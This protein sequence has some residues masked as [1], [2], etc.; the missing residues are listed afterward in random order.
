[1]MWHFYE[2]PYIP[3]LELV[4]YQSLGE[5][6]IDGILER[7]NRFLRQWQRN[8]VLIHTTLHFFLSYTHERP[9]GSRLQIF[10]AFSSDQ[11]VNFESIDAGFGK[12]LPSVRSNLK[13]EELFMGLL[14]SLFSAAADIAKETITET[15]NQ[16]ET[17]KFIKIMMER[18][19]QNAEAN[20]KLYQDW[21][22]HE[23]SNYFAAKKNTIIHDAFDVLMD[24]FE[25]TGKFDFSAVDSLSD[26]LKSSDSYKQEAADVVNLCCEALVKLHQKCCISIRFVMQTIHNLQRFADI[27]PSIRGLDR[28][29]D[30][31][32]P[33]DNADC[34]F[35]T[36]F[37]SIAEGLEAAK[38]DSDNYLAM[39]GSNSPL[40]RL[41]A[42]KDIL[43][44]ED[45]VAAVSNLLFAD[46]EVAPYAGMKKMILCLSMEETDEATALLLDTY[47][48]VIMNYLRLS[49]AKEKVGKDN[50]FIS[51]STEQILPIDL[52]IAQSIKSSK[53]GSPQE[54]DTNLD[55]FLE[56]YPLICTSSWEDQLFILQKV[57]A[58]LKMYS[59]ERKVLE[60]LVKNNIPRTEQIDRRLNFLKNLNQND[61][62]NAANSIEE[63]SIQ[64][65]DNEIAY[66]YRFISWTVS[67]IN[68]YMN[69]LTSEDKTLDLP[70]V[71][72]EWNKKI[73]QKNIRWSTD[74]MQVYL[75][76][77]LHEN[78]GDLYTT[79]IKNC[80]AVL[81]NE[82]EYEPSVYIEATDSAKYPWLSFVVTGEQLTMTQVS[83]AIYALYLPTKDSQCTQAVDTIEQN[84]KYQN[85]LI[86]LKQAQNPKIKNYIESI[87]EILISGLEAW[88][89]NN[90][91]SSM[92]D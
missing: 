10:L 60:F 42:L 67:E 36:D 45:Y 24:S 16:N 86:T 57:F 1:M 62:S 40:S 34:S 68:S 84:Q 7:H 5:Q 54:V 25:D 12:S 30:A 83:F 58:Y 53:S 18:D 13:W 17:E 69:L 81:S 76:K 38:N 55:E 91:T 15:M 46:Q 80:G 33:V 51:A 72:A 52:L 3:D 77:Y 8:T 41:A 56:Y 23:R 50:P 26:E 29:Y 47:C 43:K 39:V 78:F 9:K 64:T 70:M 65:S 21:L 71:V 11:T 28:H 20:E 37:D 49:T 87:N 63:F 2:I 44:S 92:Y 27:V 14:G 79:K 6:G 61:I 31:F 4:K 59:Q 74:A 22:T 73:P 32:F 85:R 48:T 75:D 90:N 35:L 19:A 66:D 89:N 82:V 88:L